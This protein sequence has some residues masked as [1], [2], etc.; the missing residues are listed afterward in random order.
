MASQGHSLS[1]HD[2]SHVY[3]GFLRSRP[4]GFVS[5]R[6]HVQGS[7]FKGLFLTHSQETSSASLAL[8]PLAPLACQQL[9]TGAGLRR[10]VLRALL[11]T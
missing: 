6:S 10:P 2:V 1:V 5:P 7:P 3:D 4:C 9:P 8:S 11:R